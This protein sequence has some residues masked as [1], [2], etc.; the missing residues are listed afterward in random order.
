MHEK[1][2]FL[3]LQVRNPADPMRRQEVRCF[4]RVLQCNGDQI[5]PWDL[6]AG[7]PAA[8]DLDAHDAVLL[9]GSGH[10]SATSSD[11]WIDPVLDCLRDIHRTSKPTFAS[12][13][14]FQAM[15]RAMG[16]EV[17]K[18][19]QRAELGTHW[20]HLTPAGHNDPIFSPLGEIFG[21]QMGHEDRVSR[22]PAD[23]VRLASTDLVENQAYRFEGKPIYCTQFHPELNLADLIGRVNQY[24][25]YIRR[26][27]GMPPERFG[28]LLEDTPD[29]EKLILRFVNH[30]F[31]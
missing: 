5:T 21:G 27:C 6:L 28:E 22:L 19:M 29:T 20:L 14:G 25:E 2:R 1:L 17:I 16:G 11:P 30:V 4:N 9:G 24:P 12:C 18:D 8:A 13:W 10:Y 23:A 31:G 3:L 15:A 7:P 26:I